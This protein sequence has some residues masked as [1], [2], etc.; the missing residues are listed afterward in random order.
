[1]FWYKFKQHITYFHPT[2]DITNTIKCLRN[3]ETSETRIF[4]PGGLKKV[5]FKSRKYNKNK[6]YTK[7]VLSRFF[8]G[9]ELT[10][11]YIYV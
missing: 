3:M 6:K 9:Q 1:M 4:L 7:I 2:V 5:G 8:S 10:F 11:L